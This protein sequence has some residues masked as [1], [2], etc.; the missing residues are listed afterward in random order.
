MRPHGWTLLLGGWLLMKMP[1]QG[2]ASL[3]ISRWRQVAAYDSAVACEKARIEMMD[4]RG[5]EDADSTLL[6]TR[7]VPAEHLYPP[8]TPSAPRSK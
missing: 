4:T 8:A 3:P 7:C 2:D 6:H 1:P 5:P